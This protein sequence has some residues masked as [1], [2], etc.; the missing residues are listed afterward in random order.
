MAPEER[1]KEQ[2]EFKNL[3]VRGVGTAIDSEQYKLNEEE[4]KV[5]RNLLLK[6][7]LSFVNSY[8]MKLHAFLEVDGV[9]LSPEDIRERAHAYAIGFINGNWVGEQNLASRVKQAAQGILEV[10]S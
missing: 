8:A 6:P 3:F 4:K 5:G 2:E 7:N 1:V 10:V 9:Y